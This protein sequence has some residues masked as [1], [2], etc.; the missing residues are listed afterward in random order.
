MKTV[1]LTSLLISIL[2][3]A[4]I[5]CGADN[6]TAST[7]ANRNTATAGTYGTSPAIASEINQLKTRYAC[8]SGARFDISFYTSSIASDTTIMGPFIPGNLGAATTAQSYV[9]MSVYNDLM[10]VVR[11]TNGYNVILSMCSYGV[12]L[13]PERHYSQFSASNGITISTHTNR[14]YG[15]VDAAIDTLLIADPYNAGNVSYPQGQAYT[16]F[17]RI[18]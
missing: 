10:I 11:Q 12:L 3:L 9:G 5:S 18:P 7:A 6:Q 8:T 14:S 13:K 4:L 1:K 15:S 16:T 2:S 17:F